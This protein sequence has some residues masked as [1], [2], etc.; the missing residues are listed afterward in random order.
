MHIL[1]LLL[2]RKDFVITGSTDGHIKFW[3][4]Q[5][6]SI[7]FVK[8]FRAHLGNI[9]SLAANITGARLASCSNDKSLKIFDV[10]NFGVFLNHFYHY[11]GTIFLIFTMKFTVI[12]YLKVL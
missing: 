4:K 9:Q 10:E 3:K 2:F 12:N 6:E 8:H 11:F 5:E 1:F 7:E